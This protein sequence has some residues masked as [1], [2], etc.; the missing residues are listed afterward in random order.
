MGIADGVKTANATEEDLQAQ[1]EMYQF[2]VEKYLEL[3][4]ASQQYGI[5]AWSPLDSQD[6]SSWRAGETYW[7]ME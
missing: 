6:D 5:T 3:I 4:P 2:V 1:A 7:F